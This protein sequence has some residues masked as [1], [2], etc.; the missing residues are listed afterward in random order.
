MEVETMRDLSSPSEIWVSLSLFASTT[1]LE[2]NQNLL[3]RNLYFLLIFIRCKVGQIT[4]LYGYGLIP[5][6]VP[7]FA[8]YCGKKDD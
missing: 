2:S 5:N 4:E 7:D 3:S 8:D 1:S 6:D